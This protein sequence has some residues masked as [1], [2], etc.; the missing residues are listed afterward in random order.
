VLPN[1]FYDCFFYF[2]EECCRNFDK[3]CLELDPFKY[4][5]KGWSTCEMSFSE[6][7]CCQIKSLDLKSEYFAPP[8]NHPLFVLLS[9]LA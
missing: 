1:E 4:L 6:L 9:I 7:Y 5:E 2:W 3:D 8:I